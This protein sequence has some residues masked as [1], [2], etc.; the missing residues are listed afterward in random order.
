MRNYLV[1]NFEMKPDTTGGETKKEIKPQCDITYTSLDEVQKLGNPLIVCKLDLSKAGLKTIPKEL[2]NF[3]NMQQLFLGSTSISQSEIDQLQRAMPN[4]EII[5]EPENSGVKTAN[6]IPKTG[7]V[8]CIV[9]KLN[10]RRSPS[11]NAPVIGTV[12]K[13]LHHEIC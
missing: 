4:C 12:S 10:I 11:F 2:Y 7:T 13:G 1:I 5:Y 3:T 8:I 6:N 9:A